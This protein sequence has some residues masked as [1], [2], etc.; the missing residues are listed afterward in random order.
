MYKCFFIFCLLGVNVSFAQVNTV[1]DDS[2]CMDPIGIISKTI[3]FCDTAPSSIEYCNLTWM[4]LPDNPADS[5]QLWW[6]MPGI[7][8]WS[9]MYAPHLF[10]PSGCYQFNLTLICSATADT[11]LLTSTWYVSTLGI[12]N[13]SLE[14]E[15]Q[16]T[17][18]T[19]FLGRELINPKKGLVIRY[20]TD[21][22]SQRVFITE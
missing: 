1:I 9:E 19:D 11:A 7:S 2:N 12:E 15:K 16:C 10:D 13:P 14:K 5:I 21:G 6:E 3:E 22:S 4:N 8:P 20:Y 18:T 17:R